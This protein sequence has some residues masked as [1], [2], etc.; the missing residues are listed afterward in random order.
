MGKIYSNH[1]L[2]LSYLL[3]CPVDNAGN[4]ISDPQN[5]NFFWGGEHPPDG[6][7]PYFV[8]LHC[9]CVLLVVPFLEKKF[10]LSL[11]LFLVY[12]TRITTNIINWTWQDTFD[13]MTTILVTDYCYTALYLAIPQAHVINIITWLIRLLIRKW[14]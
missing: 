8:H 4:G 14:R 3:K 2:F 1:L 12:L 9:V 5:L 7:P 6:N 13:V 10:L 11:N